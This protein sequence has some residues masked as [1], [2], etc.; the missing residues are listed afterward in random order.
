MGSGAV[1]NPVCGPFCKQKGC[2][3]ALIA[4]RILLVAQP[5]SMKNQ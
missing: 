2:A 5:R 4:N 1:N 3:D